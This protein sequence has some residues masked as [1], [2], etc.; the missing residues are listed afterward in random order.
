MV[1]KEESWVV[2]PL[3]SRSS[4]AEGRKPNEWFVRRVDG[5]GFL[6]VYTDVSLSLPPLP[7]SL[8]SAFLRPGLDFSRRLA[9]Q[10][11]PEP[12]DPPPHLPPSSSFIPLFFS[13]S[14]SLGFP[15]R[16]EGQRLQAH[17]RQQGGG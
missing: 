1:K 2:N 7:F 8:L 10:S 6:P 5:S 16:A 12:T 11:R 4:E 9:T 3:N 17:A 13:L 15:G 14:L